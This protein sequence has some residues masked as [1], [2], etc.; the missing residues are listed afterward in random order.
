MSSQHKDLLIR[1]DEDTRLNFKM[2][3]LCLVKI[4]VALVA[5]TSLTEARAIYGNYTEGMCSY[6]AT[7]SADGI[8]GV[9]VSVS[10]G[11]CGSG[12]ITSGLCPGS[13]DIKCC[14]QPACSTPSGSGTCLQTSLCSSRGGQSVSGY[15]AGPSDI[16]C[17]VPQSKVCDYQG[18][19]SVGGYEGACVSVS[20]GCC[21]SG[22]VSSGL[23][24]GSSDIKCCTQQACAT[25]YGSGTCM[26]T[27]LCSSKGGYSVGG[28]CSGPGDLQCCVSGSPP[29][30]ADSHYGV[31]ISTTV[32]DSAAS[33]FASNGI[34]FVIPRG[35][36]SVGDVDHSVCSTLNAAMNAGI[37]TRDV[38]I[39]PCP[40]CGKSAATQ[41]NELVS[42]LRGNCA[43][44]WSGRV[45]LD[46]EGTQYWL[47]DAGSN[48]Q[49]YK[50]GF[51][52]LCHDCKNVY[53]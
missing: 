14:T 31:D 19:C 22:V 40:T 47:G 24:P 48:Q 43:S 8:S 37:K 33:C 17:C 49:W 23:C 42:Y 27:S 1:V 25:P 44:A 50:V 45:W 52:V 18:T 21:S 11:C 32:S 38:Y 15:C 30:P 20:D 9:C 16:Q 53:V 13:S 7:C 12:T 41:M 2:M 29:T 26:Q 39:F 36:M 5:F 10:S 6:E 28:H 3:P 4:V 34:S 46:I 51:K 35:Y